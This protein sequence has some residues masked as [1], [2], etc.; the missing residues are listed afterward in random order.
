MKEF[1]PQLLTIILGSC[2][3]LLGAIGLYVAVLATIH[4]KYFGMEVPPLDTEALKDDRFDLKQTIEQIDIHEKIIRDRKVTFYQAI[5]CFI[6]MAVI[7]SYITLSETH[8]RWIDLPYKI[9]MLI[10]GYVI[11]HAF[12]YNNTNK[13]VSRLMYLNITLFS[14]SAGMYIGIEEIRNAFSGILIYI[15]MVL[16]HNFLIKRRIERECREEI[17]KNGMN[18][19]GINVK[20]N[21]T[22]Y[23]TESNTK[24]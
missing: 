16:N 8:N 5:G 23:G 6:G 1:V 4:K 10:N 17:K 19:N 15:M 2:Y 14:I 3:L 20:I 21:I 11:L 12:H 7:F 18:I 22:P 24:L 9:G 13:F